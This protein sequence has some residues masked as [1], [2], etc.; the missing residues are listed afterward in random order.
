M[1]RHRLDPRVAY[2]PIRIV[3]TS[4]RH[5][6]P[7]W[8]RTVVERREVD[9]P[10]HGPGVV[11]SW[12]PQMIARVPAPWRQLRRRDRRPGAGWLRGV[13]SIRLTPDVDMPA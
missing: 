3:S 4:S 2:A 13:R 8:V 10:V 11:I 12:T 7:H 9:H 1:T 5:P 6:Y